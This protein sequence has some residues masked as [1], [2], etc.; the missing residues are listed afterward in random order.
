M[1]VDAHH[2]RIRT[3]GSYLIEFQDGATLNPQFSVGYRSLDEFQPAQSGVEFI[4]DVNYI[5]P[6][7]LSLLVNGGMLISDDNAVLAS[8]LESSISVDFG[9][10]NLGLMLEVTPT[11]GQAKVSNFYS[12]RNNFNFGN[13]REANRYTNGIKLDSEISFGFLLNESSRMIFSGG[14]N[15]DNMNDGELKLGMVNKW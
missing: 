15:Q 14:Y 7:G 8:S 5:D 1:N 2:I 13:S 11:W 12:S 3:E 4:G 9:N 10:D 6:I